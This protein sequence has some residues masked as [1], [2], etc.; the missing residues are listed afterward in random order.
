MP[1]KQLDTGNDHQRNMTGAVTVW[2][3]F[4]HVPNPISLFCEW[5][6]VQISLIPGQTAIRVCLRSIENNYTISDFHRLLL[7]VPIKLVL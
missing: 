5:P 4:S 1:F 2:P 3:H 7:C 6:P